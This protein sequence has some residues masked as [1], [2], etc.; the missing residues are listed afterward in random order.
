MAVISL[1]YLLTTGMLNQFGVPVAVIFGVGPKINIFAG[2]PCWAIDRAVTAMTGQDI[3]A[4]D[5]RWVRKI[6][7]TGFYLNLP[8]TLTMVLLVQTFGE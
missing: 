5:I 8:I 1:F 4:G 6:I 7:K 3:G 2:M